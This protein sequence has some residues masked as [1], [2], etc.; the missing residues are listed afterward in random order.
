MSFL[1]PSLALAG[2]LAV[3]LPVLIHLLMRRRRKVVPWAAMRF[4]IEAYRRQRSRLRIEQ[5]LL[6]LTRCLL[7]ACAAAAIAQPLLGFAA[8]AARG[9]VWL[10]LVIDNSLASQ[11]KD[12]AG[13]SALDRHKDRAR[14]LL[15]TLSPER[16]DRAGLVTLAA[17]SDAIALPASAD[18]GAVAALLDS[19]E[20]AESAADFE[21]ALDRVRSGLESSPEQPGAPGEVVAILSEFRAGSLDPTRAVP[22]LGGSA[23]LAALPPA[24]DSVDNIAVAGVEPLR[25]TLIGAGDS[26]SAPVRVELERYGPGV[27]GETSVRVNLLASGVEAAARPIP[28]GNGLARFA[29]G[30]GSASVTIPAVIPAAR[31]GER[32]SLTAAVDRDALE[33]DSIGRTIVPTR[34]RLSVAV[35]ASRPAR[36]RGGVESF[37]AAD[38]AAL[39]L[40]PER[41][42]VG[43][44]RVVYAPPLGAGLDLANIDAALVT[45]PAA[46]APEQWA[47]L[48][49]FARDAG[50]VIVFPSLDAPQRRWFDLATEHLGWTLRLRED[51]LDFSPASA[52]QTF[53]QSPLPGSIQ[54]SLLGLVWGE[55]PD[56]AGVVRVN[57]SMAVEAPAEAILLSHSGGPL[58]LAAPVGASD[59]RTGRGLAVLFTAPL[60]LSWTD[61][62]AKPLVVPLLQ[63]LVRQGVGRAAA[64]SRVVAGATAPSGTLPART[65]ELRM[66]AGE[67][68]ASTSGL[69]VRPE[70][71]LRRAGVYVA[72]DERERPLGAVVVSPAPGAGDVGTQDRSALEPVLARIAGGPTFASG[73][74]QTGGVTW[75]GDDFDPSAAV[76]STGKAGARQ[77]ELSFPLLVAAA[78]LAVVE[79]MLA[80]MVSHASRSADPGE[81]SFAGGSDA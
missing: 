71:A 41:E 48:G 6:L 15:R 50:V 26:V 9:P 73:D 2:A 12:A 79:L 47:Q 39:A 65:A 42:G 53:E 16:G 67:D 22:A 66:V 49:S 8:G 80:R 62:P 55:L 58:V 33:A 23:V 78:I 64:D 57:K 10:T 29:A 30:R 7:V 24:N 61:L 81:V 20:G 63:E 1:H 51:A 3:A 19:I 17:P 46:L 34:Q 44:I 69:A 38:W 70:Q 75:I 43:P 28:V 18:L 21:G 4:V 74:A 32:L 56:L 77:S 54:E 72:V 11:V 35:L 37:R 36:V 27:A 13:V 52:L 45:D 59:E 68:A 31:P 76:A 5:F 40:A 60:D 14:A 25:R